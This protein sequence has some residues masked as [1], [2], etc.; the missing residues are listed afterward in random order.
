MV[1]ILRV[2]KLED[3]YVRRADLSDL[4][5]LT[6]FTM[7]EFREA[8]GIT[9]VPESICLGVKTTLED[10]SIAMYWV[11]VRDG[12]EVIGNV[13]VVKEWSNWHAGYYWWIQS[14]YIQPEYRGKGLMQKLLGAVKAAAKEDRALELRLYVHKMNT[15]AISAYRKSGFPDADYQIMK[16]KL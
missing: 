13:S 6:S 16:M 15:R 10:E 5:Q 11:L 9:E 1:H 14:M 3:F 2:M 12:A 8:E 7:A 4:E